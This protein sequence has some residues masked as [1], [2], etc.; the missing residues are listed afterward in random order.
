MSTTVHLKVTKNH[1]GQVSRLP[2]HT[3]STST[4]PV[5]YGVT[6]SSGTYSLTVSP[7]PPPPRPSPSPIPLP[8][9]LTNASRRNLLR[10]FNPLRS[11][12]CTS[13]LPTLPPRPTTSHNFRITLCIHLCHSSRV[14][15]SSSLQRC[16]LTSQFHLPTSLG[17]RMRW[18]ELMRGD[19]YR[20]RRS[21]PCCGLS[22]RSWSLSCLIFT[23]SSS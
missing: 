16:L 23:T 8:H 20:C 12:L 19:V 13:S 17:A 14:R 3:L 4:L 21:Y 6:L 5:L 2:S 10:L 15:F 7:T 22:Y 1:T 11:H 9:S 18:P